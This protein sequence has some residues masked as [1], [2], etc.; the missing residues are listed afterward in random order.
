MA[1][2]KLGFFINQMAE[3]QDFRTSFDGSVPLSISTVPDMIFGMRQGPLN[4]DQDVRN[5]IR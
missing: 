1:L 3:N 4:M 2:R 5:S